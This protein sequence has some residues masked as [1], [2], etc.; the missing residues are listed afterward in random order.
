MPSW[1]NQHFRL[2]KKNHTADDIKSHAR[3]ISFFILYTKDKIQDKCVCLFSQL[4]SHYASSNKRKRE[5]EGWYS[6]QMIYLYVYTTRNREEYVS[7]R[8]CFITDINRDH[9]SK[10]SVQFIILFLLY[11]LCF[12]YGNWTY[13]YKLNYQKVR[14]KSTLLWSMPYVIFDSLFSSYCHRVPVDILRINK[15]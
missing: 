13:V 12:Y 9:Y 15:I 11:N 3:R 1:C 10:I 4:I 5:R 6:S 14:G 8:F 7:N 2:V